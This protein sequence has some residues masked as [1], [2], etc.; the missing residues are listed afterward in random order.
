MFF[1]TTENKYIRLFLY[2]Y[3]NIKAV[4]SLPQ[5]TFA[6][7]TN[8]KTSILFAQKKTREQI[9]RWNEIWNKYSKEYA[10]LKT[11]VENLIDVYK[12]AKNKAKLPSIKNLSIDEERQIL[13]RFLENYVEYGDK[14]L[15]N[16]E[17]VDKYI[18]E[19]NEL[20]KYD[21]DT[22]DEFGFVNTW[23]VFGEVSKELD[24]DIFMAETDLIGYKR[25]LRSEKI[26]PNDLY[27]TDENGKIIVDDGKEEAIVDYMRNNIKWE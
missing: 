12:G 16:T 3:F 17:L 2:K 9:E 26:T 23:W 21:T 1:D 8:T 19:L 4:I 7:Y 25:T 15:S 10:N 13:D 20:C 5:I 18:D 27:R 6:P 14:A 24:Y 11:R 22:K